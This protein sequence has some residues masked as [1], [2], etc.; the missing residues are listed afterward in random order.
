MMRQRISKTEGEYLAI[1]AVATMN[2]TCFALD[3]RFEALTQAHERFSI[4]GTAAYVHG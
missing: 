4:A 3:S 2:W 1:H